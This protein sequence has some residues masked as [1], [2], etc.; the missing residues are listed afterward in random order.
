MIR[1][2]WPAGIGRR[3]RPSGSSR[4]SRSAIA[5]GMPSTSAANRWSC[6]WTRSRM[7][8]SWFFA[9]FASVKQ[10]SQQP[11]VDELAGRPREDVDPLEPPARVGDQVAATPARRRPEPDA[12]ERRRL[13]ADRRPP[14]GRALRLCEQPVGLVEPQQ[15]L[16]LD[17]EDQHPQVRGA[18][19]RR[20]PARPSAR[21]GRT[22][23][24]RS[25]SRRREMPA[26][27]MWPPLRPSKKSRSTCT[28]SAVA[29]EARPAAAAPSGRRRARERVPRRSRA[30]TGLARVGGDP[31]LG[32]DPRDGDARGPHLLRRHDAELG[33]P[34]R[35]GLVL[36]A[37]VD[38]PPPRS[39]RRTCAPRR[40]SG[41]ACARRPDRP[42][43]GTRRPRAPRGTS[44]VRVCSD[45]RTRPT[46][47]SLTRPS[48]SHDGCAQR[49]IH[50]AAGRPSGGGAAARARRSA[51]GSAAPAGRCAARRRP[52][53]GAPPSRSAIATTSSERQVRRGLAAHDARS[54]SGRRRARRAA[55]T[56]STAGSRRS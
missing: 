37:L 9:S 52:A 29:A 26:I 7:N 8:G 40:P 21:A 3:Q 5:P 41:P 31:D 33:D 20:S 10:N 47:S 13:D 39:R 34:V 45:P 24:T 6:C 56:R 27:D 19:R 30:S 18:P 44:A 36:R 50:E 22:A 48:G 12:G 23:R 53:A 46:C 38:R 1:P 28:G 43:A 51:P 11:E 42:A 25:W 55:R 16:A 17:V 49:A 54:T 35:V 32:V 15:V 4:G 2:A 14:L